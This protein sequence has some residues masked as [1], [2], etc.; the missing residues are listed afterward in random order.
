MVIG[1]IVEAIPEKEYA[2]ISILNGL[3]QKD[4]FYSLIQAFS[5]EDIGKEVIVCMT[6]DNQE[7]IVLGYFKK[8]LPLGEDE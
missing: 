3:V 1:K 5:I 6:E 8:F 4:K 7:L 2:K